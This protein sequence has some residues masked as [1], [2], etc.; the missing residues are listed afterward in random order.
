MPTRDDLLPHYRDDLAKKVEVVRQAILDLAKLG[1][2]GL[3]DVSAE[4]YDLIRLSV[5]NSIKGT[6][7]ALSESSR[8]KWVEEQ[9]LKP[10]KKSGLV[11]EYEDKSAEGKCDFIGK[12]AAGKR[13]GLEV[14]GGEG[15]SVTLFSRPAGT[16]I[17]AVWSFLDVMSNTPGDNMRAVLGRVV[18]Q[19]IN[20]DE[21]QERVDVL[22]FYDSWYVKGIKQF[23]GGRVPMPD[24][25]VFPASIPT[26]SNPHPA[27]ANPATNEFL[28]ALYQVT[29]GKPVAHPTVKEHVW[30]CDLWVEAKGK[31]WL[32][33]MTLKNWAHPNV[34]MSNRETLTTAA[35]PAP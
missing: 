26:Q 29:A 10:A 27:P 23:R 3:E 6:D 19:M 31:D 33:G 20:R 9:F 13:F 15:N 1:M 5:V 2:P 18:K 34:A 12:L 16:D 35:K 24:V 4:D 21:K 32:R 22:V 17:L 25:I 7:I 28:N 30:V 11:S 8:Q 14:K